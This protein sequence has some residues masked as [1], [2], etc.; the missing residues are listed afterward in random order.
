MSPVESPEEIGSIW[1]T[2][3][4]RASPARER[5]EVYETRAMLDEGAALLAM[6]TH[7]N[8]HVLI[9]VSPESEFG[10]DRRSGGVHLLTRV[11]NDGTEDRRY[12]D[13]VC[14]KPHLDDVFSTFAGELLTELIS[15]NDERVGIRVRSVLEHWRDL[16]ARERGGKLSRGALAGLFGELWYLRELCRRSP[17]AL[18]A[19]KGP[20]GGRHDFR[21]PGVAL[22][23]KTTLRSQGRVVEVHGHRQ[24]LPPPESDLFLAFLRLEEAEVGRSVPDLVEA[25]HATGLDR[26]EFEEKL[27]EAGYD[28][29]MEESYREYRFH[30]EETLLY[31]VDEVFPRIIPSS[32]VHRELPAG[33]LS[34]SYTIDLSGP[35]LT[36]LEQAERK[37][38]YSSLLDG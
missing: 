16:F 17:G 5:F 20:E 34:L 22:E 7:G 19:W 30:V 32:F 38:L 1:R 28:A 29:S 31:C 21:V 25:L 11:L 35:G 37:A 27:L 6:D 26:R 8:R 14:L 4:K 13:L 24:L 36:P 33:V 23:I 2:L 3:E 18:D 15:G 12:I 9:P 10:A